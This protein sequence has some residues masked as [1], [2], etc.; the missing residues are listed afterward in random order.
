MTNLPS[1]LALFRRS[2]M[3]RPQ[4]LQWG[5]SWKVKVSRYPKQWE[6]FFRYHPAKLA[7]HHLYSFHRWTCRI[8]SD[9]P[10]GVRLPLEALVVLA[11]G[12]LSSSTVYKSVF[13][14]VEIHEGVDAGIH[15]TEVRIESVQWSGFWSGA[16]GFW[17]LLSLAFYTSVLS[18][19][20]S[21]RSLLDDSTPEWITS[22]DISSDLS[23]ATNTYVTSGST[24]QTRYFCSISSVVKSF[25][26]RSG[27]GNPHQSHQIEQGFEI[28]SLQCNHI[29]ED[30]WIW[31]Y[32][33][34]S[35]RLS[36]YRS[37]MCSN[38]ACVSRPHAGNRF[39]ECRYPA[40]R[41][42]IWL[43][44]TFCPWFA[45]MPTGRAKAVSWNSSTFA[46]QDHTP[47]SSDGVKVFQ[48][49]ECV[50]WLS[51]CA[52]EA[53]VELPRVQELTAMGIIYVKGCHTFSFTALS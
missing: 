26:V 46:I 23:T 37:E 38:G 50:S 13:P 7:G 22:W 29:V 45:V 53:S 25:S 39:P 44:S 19:R 18:L 28:T 33:S 17:C 3:N 31:M 40:R 20:L 4:R 15:L 48:H 43:C 14:V 12:T 21:V 36:S 32:H 5:S 10:L 52:C 35:F 1:C 51:K 8:D 24:H 34:K 41:C 9:R 27:K 42:S 30:V 49:F 16:A 11:I 6:V 47:L 2:L